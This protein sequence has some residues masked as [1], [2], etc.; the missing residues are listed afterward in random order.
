MTAWDYAVV[1]AGMAGASVG[2][3]LAKPGGGA[4]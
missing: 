4:A 1:G 3:Q 2:W